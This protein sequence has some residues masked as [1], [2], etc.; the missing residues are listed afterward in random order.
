MVTDAIVKDKEA[1]EKEAVLAMDSDANLPS[2]SE[3][4]I[5]EGDDKPLTVKG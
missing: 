1:A 4:E 2:S 5:E 3:D